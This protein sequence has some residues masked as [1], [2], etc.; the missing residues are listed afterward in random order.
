MTDDYKVQ[1]SIS[2]P[3]SAQYAKGDMVNFRASSVEELI[4]MLEEAN[5]FDLYT[6]AT[7]ASKAMLLASGLGATVTNEAAP[8]TQAAGPIAQVK[9]CPH[10]TRQRRTG[11]GGDTGKRAWAAHFCPLEK[12]DVNQCKPEFE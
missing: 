3:P 12:G 7:E 2:L 5:N 4:G 9:T 11:G 8:A 6:P 10:G 1:F